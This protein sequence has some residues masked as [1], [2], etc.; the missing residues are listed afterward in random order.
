MFLKK[1]K[2]MDL[3]GQKKTT[4]K[5]QRNKNNILEKKM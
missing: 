3:I 5:K 4:N 2:D 1:K